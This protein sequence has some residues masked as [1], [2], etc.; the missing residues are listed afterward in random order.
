MKTQ[1]TSFAACHRRNKSP[2]FLIYQQT[3]LF[4]VIL[5]DLWYF[6]VE[7]RSPYVSSLTPFHPSL[8]S[9][10][11]KYLYDNS[12]EDQITTRLYL[13]WFPPIAFKTPLRSH[14]F[15][16][17]ILSSFTCIICFSH[18]SFKDSFT[19]LF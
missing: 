16:F 17:I 4:V 5:C 18:D 13:R 14:I 2:Q 15:Y 1:N 12:A 6:D 9:S 10:R 7:E 8:K 19:K 11:Y 3:R